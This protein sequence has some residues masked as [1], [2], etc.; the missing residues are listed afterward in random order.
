MFERIGPI[1]AILT[2]TLSGCGITPAGEA[3]EAVRR[4]LD[5]PDSAKFRNVEV[6][7]KDQTLV[8]GDVNSKNHF[9][10]YDGFQPFFV[11]DGSV[12]F[13]GDDRFIPLINRCYGNISPT[14]NPS[15]DQIT[16]ESNEVL[17]QSQRVQDMA[18]DAIHDD[19]VDAEQPVDASSPDN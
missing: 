4:R 7:S 12:I 2:L 10:G 9:G 14:D 19:A 17:R 6:C 5:D 1:L 8:S 15:D 18:R 3:E 13:A 16:R 11:K